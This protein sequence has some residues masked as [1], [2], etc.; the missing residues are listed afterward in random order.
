MKIS[1]SLV[2]TFCHNIVST[3][4]FF[5]CIVFCYPLIYPEGWLLGTSCLFSRGVLNKFLYGEAPPRK[6]N[7]LPFYMSLLGCLCG[8]VTNFGF[9]SS[10]SKDGLPG[11]GRNE[12]L[13]PRNDVL[14]NAFIGFSLAQTLARILFVPRLR[15]PQKPR[16]RCEP[17]EGY[18]RC[19]KRFDDR[20][21][22]IIF[23]WFEFK[24]VDDVGAG[25]LR[26][27]LTLHTNPHAVHGRF[28]LKDDCERQVWNAVA[29]S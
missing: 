18:L 1:G 4:L 23:L 11:E 3:L 13:V 2:L 15:T 17:E 19:L 27:M 29:A 22:S 5:I 7:P 28:T 14:T 8:P 20:S 16:R 26:E 24:S 6:S 25:K 12:C 9:R 10:V 21:H